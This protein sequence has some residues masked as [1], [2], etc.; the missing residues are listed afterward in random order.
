LPRTYTIAA[1]VSTPATVAHNKVE[2]FLLQQHCEQ[3]VLLQRVSTPATLYTQQSRINFYF[4]NIASYNLRR[5]SARSS[6][7]S[8]AGVDMYTLQQHC[9]QLI[10]HAMLQ[11]SFLPATE[12]I[13]TTTL[14]FLFLS[15]LEARLVICSGLSLVSLALPYLKQRRALRSLKLLGI[16]C[17]LPTSCQHC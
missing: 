3:H 13:T 14:L 9:Q 12:T 7:A 1:Y 17:S 6:I 16:L 5:V 8:N 4:S 2:S 10:L 11:R 15:E